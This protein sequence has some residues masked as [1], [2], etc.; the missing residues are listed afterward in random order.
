[1]DLK[2]EGRVAIVTG[3]S[4]GLGRASVE[5]LVAEGMKV[6]AIAAEPDH[7]HLL[8]LPGGEGGMPPTWQ[9][10]RWI[11]RWKALTSKRLKSLPGLDDFEWQTGYALAAVSGGK[12]G[13]QDALAIVEAYVRAQGDQSDEPEAGDPRGGDSQG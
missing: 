12:Q 6:I 10:S 8:G 13:A 1:M 7:V 4:R 5:A 2:L 3:A 9:W 11:G